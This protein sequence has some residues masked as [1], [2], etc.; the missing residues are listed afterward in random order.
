MARKMAWSSLPANA[1]SFHVF[2]RDDAVVRTLQ[3]SQVAVHEYRMAYDNILEANRRERYEHEREK[4]LLEEELRAIFL[5]KAEAD[6]LLK[7]QISGLQAGLRASEQAFSELDAEHQRLQHTSSTVTNE[8]RE[9]V[10]TLQQTVAQ[11]QAEGHA[12]QS[13]LTA[14]QAD[15][16]LK[17]AAMQQVADLQSAIAALQQRAQ[18]LVSGLQRDK[19]LAEHRVA[20]LSSNLAATQQ[21]LA[22]EA[23]A[24]VSLDDIAGRLARERQQLT[25][26]LELERLINEPLRHSHYATTTTLSHMMRSPVAPTVK[27]RA[28]PDRRPA[29]QHRHHQPHQPL[30]PPHSP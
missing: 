28:S 20:Q 3:G 14:V 25:A 10:D 5:A 24:R 2:R 16:A 11:L 19:T 30:A 8:L 13:E 27:N 29:A 7:G 1:P 23:A 9:R 17:D 15:A 26:A 6:R 22:R 12:L 21:Q 18:H 4:L